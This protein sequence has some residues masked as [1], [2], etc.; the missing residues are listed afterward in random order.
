MY[1]YTYIYTYI[2]IYL[3]ESHGSFKAPLRLLTMPSESYSE[4]IATNCLNFARALFVE[5][6]NEPASII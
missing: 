6:C 1:I 5:A 3:Q 2:N 4:G